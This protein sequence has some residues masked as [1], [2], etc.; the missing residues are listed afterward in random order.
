M[1]A[2]LS[3]RINFFFKTVTP[4]IKVFQTTHTL[5]VVGLHLLSRYDLMMIAGK[6]DETLQES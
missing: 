4:K 6:S 3:D 5:K 2:K 1:K